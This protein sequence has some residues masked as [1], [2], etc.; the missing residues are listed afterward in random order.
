MTFLIGLFL[1]SVLGRICYFERVFGIK[2]VASKPTRI[3]FYTKGKVD[4]TRT[5]W[6]DFS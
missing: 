3:N 4:T 5:R 1:E 6:Y 2:G